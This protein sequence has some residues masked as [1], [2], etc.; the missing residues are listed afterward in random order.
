MDEEGGFNPVDAQG[1]INI[2]ALRLKAHN[3]VLR[4]RKP[5]QWRLAGKWNDQS[6]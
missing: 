4:E 6:S 5:Y 2:H 1:F 3:I